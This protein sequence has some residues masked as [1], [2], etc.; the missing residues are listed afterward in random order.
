MTSSNWPPDPPLNR[1]WLRPFLPIKTAGQR[2]GVEQIIAERQFGASHPPMIVVF[3][4]PPASPVTKRRNDHL[5][6]LP[7]FSTL[8][9]KPIW[10]NNRRE[11]L[12]TSSAGA[13][14]AVTSQ[15]IP[16]THNAWIGVP[17]KEDNTRWY[18]IRM[19]CSGRL[20]AEKL[21][22]YILHKNEKNNSVTHLYDFKTSW[23]QN[24]LY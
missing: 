22:S 19:R 23:K 16:A 24:T 21:F 4:Q 14:T 10:Q 7:A 1:T 20:S 18:R 6:G 8:L 11:R 12:T 15:A 13:T 9:A 17:A 2:S 3:H 5:C